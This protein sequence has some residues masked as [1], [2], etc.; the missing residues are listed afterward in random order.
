L[1]VGLGALPEK[2]GE[3]P[4]ARFRHFSGILPSIPLC[5]FDHNIVAIAPHAAYSIRQIAG[6]AAE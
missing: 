5:F 4:A 2:N 3:G 6:V 1:P